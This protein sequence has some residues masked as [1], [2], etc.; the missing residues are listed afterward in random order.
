MNIFGEGF[1]SEINAQINHR[2]KVYGSGYVEKSLRTNDEILYL[3]AN[4]SWCKLISGVDVSSSIDINNPTIKSLNL[5]S[6]E[7]AK[8]FVLFN[9]T[10]NTDDGEQKAGISP[11]NSLLGYNYAYG[12]GGTDEFGFK[13]MMGITNANIKHENR[14]S[15]RRA[16][17]TIKAFN[18]AQFEIIDALYLRLGFSVL[19]EWGHSMI[20]DS[21]GKINTD[22]KNEYSL[23]SDFLSG[24]YT[25][26]EFLQKIYDQRLAS[27]GNYDAMLAKVANFSWTYN[28]DG[29][30]DIRVKLSSIGDVI[31]SLKVN[32]LT[33]STGKNNTSEK[34][35]N[36]D[37]KD[38]QEKQKNNADIFETNIDGDI[39]NAF[40]YSSD[41]ANFLY[42]CKIISD[43]WTTRRNPTNTDNL[44]FS[45]YLLGYTKGT[46]LY[47]AVDYD[48]FSEVY[49][50]VTTG[51]NYKIFE[52]NQDDL[53]R[54]R[55]DDLGGNWGIEFLKG[56]NDDTK[57]YIRLG[58]FLRYLEYYIIPTVYNKS[59]SSN[60]TLKID[61][62]T[63]TNLMNA[64]P[65]Q[66]SL[67][68]RICYV[69]RQ[70]DDVSIK[71]QGKASN[72]YFGLYNTSN[73]FIN[74]TI[75][76]AVKGAKN[77]DVSYG[78]IMNIY[79]ESVFILKTIEDFK[80]DK[81]NLALIDFLKALMSG[82][83][84]GLGGINDFDV[85][86]DE[87][88]NTIRIIDKNPLKY[89]DEVI[90]ALNNNYSTNIK[91]WNNNRNINSSE[92]SAILLLN[93]Y[94]RSEAGF[95]SDFSLTTE[96]SSD[97]STMITAG[98][99]ARGTV[100]GEN[101]TALSKLNNG[102]SD[103]YKIAISNTTSSDSNTSNE[104]NTADTELIKM[105]LDFNEFLY[106]LSCGSIDTNS[107]RIV[108]VESQDID[109]NRGNLASIIQKSLQV[110]KLNEQWNGASAPDEYQ[111]TGFIP[112]NMGLTMNGL[113]GIKINQQFLMDT[114]FL[115][116]NYPTTLKF[117]IK[118]L[119]HE[120]NNNKW[121]T[122]IETYSI[123]KEV[124]KVVKNKSRLYSAKVEATTPKVTNSK[125]TLTTAEKT[126]NQIKVKNL[127]KAA[128]LT[129]VQVAGVMGNIQKE[130]GFNPLA[131]NAVD[132]N[133]YPSCGLIQWNG[134]FT[135]VSTDKEKVYDVIG[136]TVEDQIKYLLNNTSTMKKYLT[137]SASESKPYMAGYY[138]AKIVEVCYNCNKG[139]AI[140]Q[141]DTNYKPYNRSEYAVD[142]YNRFNKSGDPLFW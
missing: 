8:Q 93:G 70:I 125:S 87:T 14:G 31:E 46:S 75:T 86:V 80:D 64:H 85:F 26:D 79:L 38:T 20:I 129:Q 53:L 83:N 135:G 2:Q 71:S 54:V 88:C 78:N 33:S 42:R 12:I 1:P 132:L 4:T 48:T 133:G 65:L 25:Y 37:V 18:R 28:K 106:K 68:P 124:D 141:G 113:S 10:F 62:D 136:R 16:E 6:S 97:F 90:K 17:V 3:N 61:T 41:I 22:I 32:I 29:S 23:S 66:V 99:A 81:G 36:V 140:Y 47:S 92:N 112:F 11:T 43:S 63:N 121:V 50:K 130:S 103:R 118:N 116:T 94:A 74:S 21:S 139:L 110:D 105:R 72:L 127:L 60:K 100:V 98:A 35:G 58:A 137:T 117:L 39:I 73:P 115:P 101:D 69:S 52:S 102:F 128:G 49:T 7:L 19:L 91:K 114:D 27:A 142:F 109:S 119:S 122:K 30:Y 77:V 82:I 96:L 111:G 76:N 5:N 67:D 84:V 59:N 89:V 131:T 104:Y 107:W 108:G 44:A 126:Q 55:F 95:I 57:Y 34:E 134:K 138:F 51:F 24:K 120:I 123:P 56:D 9:G 40:S 15:L 45:N 13:P